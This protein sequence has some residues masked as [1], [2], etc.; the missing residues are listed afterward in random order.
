MTR[1]FFPILKNNFRVMFAI[2]KD[3]KSKR[4]AIAMYSLFALAFL[5]LFG[6]IGYMIY[7]VINLL[8]QV[9]SGEQ[10]NIVLSQLVSS[11]MFAS[12]IMVLFLG[13]VTTISLLFNS[14]DTELLMVLPAKPLDIFLA[15][16]VTIYLL[17]LGLALLIQIPIL[18]MV[19]IVAKIKISA[20]YILGILGSF[21]TPFIPLF[22]I[23]IIAVPCQYIISF[24][25]RNN[26]IGTIVALVLFT[27]FFGLYYYLIFAVQ[28]SAISG[29]M[30]TEEIQNIL[31]IL[32]YIVYP[33]KFLSASMFTSGI[34]E[35]KNFSIF[36]AIIV[37]LGL[38]CILLSSVLYKGAIR[39]GLES[40]AKTNAKQKDIKEKTPIS[41]LILR[42]VK[43]CFGDT[44]M[45]LN[46]LVGLI[47]APII[48]CIMGVTFPTMT[49][50]ESDGMLQ[51]ASS[52]SCVSI[53]FGCG[54]NY[55]AIVGFSREGRQI[56]LLKTM[57][58]S[59]K[60]IINQKLVISC[61]YTFLIATIIVISMLIAKLNFVYAFLEYIILLFAGNAIN[62]IVLYRDIKNPNFVWNNTKELFKNNFKSLIS[63]LLS[64]LVLIVQ[65][66]C[67]IVFPSLMPNNINESLYSLAVLA[68]TLIVSLLFLIVAMCVYY[69]K[70]KKEY[71]T[72]EM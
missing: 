25:K 46:H 39:R 51:V 50:A 43:C 72:M 10:L 60:I 21:L 32:E 28:N 64:F 2:G 8:M 63:M 13:L 66:V 70:L 20:Y 35:L 52:I 16:F 31:K 23:S 33:N 19:G 40:S 15:K 29:G 4:K 26:F 30:S 68:P 34:Q 57:P 37:V 14:K 53:I 42:D 58:V 36:L 47:I 49:E 7:N 11:T 22:V 61:I 65:M 41:A 27:A 67:L 44:S 17:Q 48:I 5:P 56:D 12:E 55:F 3:K 18:L 1:A 9:M 6:L 24:F 38:V 54:M 71:N 62:I 59:A 45:A 69:P